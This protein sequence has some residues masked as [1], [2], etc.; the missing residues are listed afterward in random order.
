MKLI[1]IAKFEENV[2]FFYFK[3]LGEYAAYWA[4]KET[5]IMFG[6]SLVGAHY[7]FFNDAFD[8]IEASDLRRMKEE[9][10][11]KLFE[12]EVDLSKA[13]IQKSKTKGHYAVYLDYEDERIID[14]RK[15]FDIVNKKFWGHFSLCSTKAA[16]ICEPKIKW[17]TIT[18]KGNKNLDFWIHDVSFE[19]GQK[20]NGERRQNKYKNER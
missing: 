16:G 2:G 19:Q 14:L 13:R 4:E 9:L 15:G 1:G 20:Q 6:Q 7:T 11:G 10:D 5:G 12:F 17:K 3:G 8:K 18:D